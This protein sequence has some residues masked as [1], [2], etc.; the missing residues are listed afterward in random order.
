MSETTSDSLTLTMSHADLT[1]MAKAME[2][3][4]N[5]MQLEFAELEEQKIELKQDIERQLA[6]LSVMKS[7]LG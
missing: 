2:N 1:V 5:S 6:M 7:R 3:S 4:V